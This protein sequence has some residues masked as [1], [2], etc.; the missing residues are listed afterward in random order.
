MAERGTDVWVFLFLL[1][2]FPG[3]LLGGWLIFHVMVAN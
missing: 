2:L 1:A 3:V